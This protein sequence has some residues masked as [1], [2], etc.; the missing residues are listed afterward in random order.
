MHR[1]ALIVILPIALCLAAQPL[2]AQTADR[3]AIAT[4]LHQK[5][6]QLHQIRQQRATEEK[7][8]EQQSA[9]LDNQIDRLKVDVTNLESPVKSQRDTVADLEK[10]V[11]AHGASIRASSA[12]LKIAADAL[13]GS[14]SAIHD[15]I[16]AGIPYRR[17]ERAQRFAHLTE[18][19]R[20]ND[21]DARAAALSDYWAAATEELRLAGT[22]QLWNEPV[23]LDGGKRQVNA[24]QLRLGLVNQLFIT[25]DG[26]TAGTAAMRA[27][28]DWLPIAPD[29]VRQTFDVA[30][31][32]KSA[33]ITPI[34]FQR[35]GGQP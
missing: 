21:P 27:D 2:H 30:R 4:E 14:A 20:G 28:T 32:Q 15:R 6:E 12:T 33:Q 17:D 9:T 8:L 31:Q 23:K 19:L 1:V 11:A 35:R 26:H 34:P 29:A 18:A 7:A 5:I 10:R 25:E 3:A 24:Y 22:M 13:A 16:A